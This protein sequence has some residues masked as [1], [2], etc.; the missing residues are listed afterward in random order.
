MPPP[1]NLTDRVLQ[2]PPEKQ[3]LVEEFIE[4]LL[5]NTNSKPTFREA[6]DNFKHEHPELLQLLA[7]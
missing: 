3:A 7:Q 5:K 4:T 1:R 2:L 6:L